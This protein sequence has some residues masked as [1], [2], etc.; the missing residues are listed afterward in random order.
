MFFYF[1]TFEETIILDFFLQYS[2]G[3]FDIIVNNRDHNFFQK[4]SPLSLWI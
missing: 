4:A 1:K 3:F 2:Q